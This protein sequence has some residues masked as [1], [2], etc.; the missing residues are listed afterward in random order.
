[1][2]FKDRSLVATA[3]RRMHGSMYMRR[4]I[5]VMVCG[6]RFKGKSGASSREKKKKR[7]SEGRQSEDAHTETVGAL[8]R[9]LKKKSA[10]EGSDKKKRAR[11]AKKSNKPSAKKAG[12]SKR[13]AVEAKTGK[14]VKKIQKRISKGMGKSRK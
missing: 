11:A 7:S 9:I 13:A 2:L 12:V 10:D 3:L 6:R 4:D 8:R 5:R 14:R 1:V